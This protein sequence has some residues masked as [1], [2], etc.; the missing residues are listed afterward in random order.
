MIHIRKRSSSDPSVDIKAEPVDLIP[1]FDP[2]E[3][4]PTKRRRMILEV[5]VPTLAEVNRNRKDVRRGRESVTIKVRL[6]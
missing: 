1:K 5:V 4:T 6:S 2:E 3:N